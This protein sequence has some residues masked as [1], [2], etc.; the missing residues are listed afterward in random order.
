[1]N[2]DLLHAGLRLGGTN[3]QQ[4]QPTAQHRDSASGRLVQNAPSQDSPL[5][6]DC[7]EAVLRVAPLSEQKPE[8]QLTTLDRGAYRG[9]P[10]VR[11]AG[12]GR[13]VGNPEVRRGGW[14]GMATDRRQGQPL[15]PQG[16]PCRLGI[17]LRDPATRN[18]DK[19]RRK[20]GCNVTEPGTPISQLGGDSRIHAV[21]NAQPAA[22]WRSVK[23]GL[24]PGHGIR[25]GAQL[26][27][28][29]LILLEQSIDQRMPGLHTSGNAH[30][31]NDPGDSF[32]HRFDP[33]REFGWLRE[34]GV[35][36]A[37]GFLSIPQVP[38]P[39]TSTSLSIPSGRRGSAA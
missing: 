29:P 26:F 18:R 21:E 14:A 19:K 20:C 39:A 10:H 30:P 12:S 8:P 35:K 6:Q 1:V 13:L 2:G 33:L 34:L 24:V 22:P 27:P 36:L 15:A 17:S 9:S 37:F 25:I 16:P 32:S 28:S 3:K 31:S 38:P 7:T 23:L 4:K 11:I 5:A